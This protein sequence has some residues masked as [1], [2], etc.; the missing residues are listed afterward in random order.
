MLTL[1]R[2]AD[3]KKANQT[4]LLFHTPKRQKLSHSNGTTE[5]ASDMQRPVS[6]A[7]TGKKLTIKP[8]KNKPK[9][10]DDFEETLWSKLKVAVEA[11]HKVKPVSYPKEEL[12]RAC[13][14]I[15]MNK[16]AAMVYDRLK[17][18]CAQRIAS[19]IA[20]LESSSIDPMSFLKHV[21]TTW[22]SHCQQMITIRSIFLFLDRTYVIQTSGI[23]G[24]W[25][26]GLELFREN[27][28]TVGDVETRCRRGL[29][30]M[31]ELEREGN[32]VDRASMKVILRMLRDLDIYAESFEKYFLEATCRFYSAESARVLVETTTSEYMK[33]AERRLAEEND[34]LLQYLDPS[35]RKSVI[36][37]VERQLISKHVEFVLGRGFVDLLDGNRREDL[38]LLY[39][40]LQRVQSTA[41]LRQAFAE[42]VK[43]K[44]GMLVMD[45]EKQKTV[46]QELLDLKAK[47]DL[48]LT[49]SFHDNPTFAHAIKE[50]FESAINR[51]ENKPAELIAKYLDNLLKSGNKSQSDEEMDTVF[52]RVMILFR[53]VQGKDVFEAFYKKDLAKRLLMGRSASFDAE[54]AVISKLKA[55]CGNAFTDHLEGMFKD[56]DLSKE[57]IAS[58]KQTSAN[59]A[60]LSKI[61]LNV[62]VLTHSKWPP[63]PPME[64]KLPSELG[65]LQEVFK[66]FYLSKYSGRRLQ[67]LNSHGQC[68]LKAYFPKGTKEL[69]VSLFQAV[70][71]LQFN[72]SD[73][74]SYEEL[75]EGTGI[76]EKELQRTLLSLACGKPGFRVIKKIPS[77]PKVETGDRFVYNTEF[78]QKLIKIKINQIQLKETVEENQNTQERVFQDRQYQVDAAIVRVMKMRRTLTHNLLITELFGQVRFPIKAQDIKKRIESLIDRE[79]MERDKNNPQVY[80]YLA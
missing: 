75:K 16:K 12:Y 68:T 66:R 72:D 58:F 14:D 42:Y 74:I 21:E 44:V 11:I 8:F 63:Y 5:N 80:N 33:Y 49:E 7:K 78:S 32:M 36:A 62:Y 17:D 51:R 40:L 70:I 46:V 50:S 43:Q 19:V 48:I 25:D 6:G 9:L 2:G 53:Y 73:D 4:T 39:S 28:Q 15:C 41:A 56:I 18:L 61:D 22:L 31:I 71:L 24:L 29:L 79:Y 60:K 38:A 77:G 30:Q 37:A 35:T 59:D 20:E 23:R 34:R 47:L 57:I 13:E 69:Q 76:E 27:F 3:N 65:Q 54:K 45:D 52:D 64:V 55:E 26:M 10:P 67:W 1:K